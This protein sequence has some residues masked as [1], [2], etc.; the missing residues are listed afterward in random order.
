MQVARLNTLLR[1]Q[2]QV[3]RRHR[4]QLHGQRLARLLQDNPKEFFSRFRPKR[5]AAAAHLRA[6][7]WQQH[8][9]QLLG[10]APPNLPVP[11]Q[12]PVIPPGLQEIP[13]SQQAATLNVPFTTGDV[14]EAVRK[15]KSGRAVVGPLKP[16]VL[17]QVAP[18]LAPALASLLNACVRIGC[19]PPA[20][21]LSAITPTPKADSNTNVCNGY[22]GIAVGTLPAKLYAAILDRR[23]SNWAEGAGIRAAGQF[24]F[25][26]K[27][28]CA[29]AAFVLRTAIERQ[30]A[31]D[32]RL[33]ACF[34]DF[35]KAYDTVPRHLLWVKLQRAGLHGWFLQA[36]QALYAD[37]P[38]CVKTATG[39]T[40]PF[41]SLLGVKQGCPLSPNLFG[42]YVDDI[43]RTMLADAAAMDLPCM[44]DGRP[45]PPLLYADD[46]V[47]LATSAEGLQKQ[48]DALQAYSDSWGL[49][50]NA[51]KTKV[52]AFGRR[53]CAASLTDAGVGFTC[54]NAL[55]SI[56]DE[57]KYLGIQFHSSQAF[58]KAAAARAASGRRAV[59]ATRRRCTELGLL[60]PDLHMRMFNTMA[61]PVL[62]YGA[63]IWS[64]Q[65]VAAGQEC[66]NTRVQMSFLRQM[67]GVRQ[68]TPSLVVLAESGHRPLA[69][70]WTLQLARFWNNL[71][72]S[73]ED[74]LLQ[75]ALADSIDLAAN[76]AGPLAQQPWAAQFAAAMRC[77]NVA[78]DLQNPQQ[79]RVG[80]VREGCTDWLLRQFSDAQG[81][82]IRHY[83][84]VVR[85]GAADDAC[86][87]A[88][89]LA[90][91]PQRARRRALAQ[92][93]TGAHWLAEETGR[94]QRQER[95][96]RLCVHCSTLG[97]QHIETVPHFIFAC[98]RTAALRAQFPQ[99]FQEAN[100]S[101]AQFF[102]QD[103]VQL[104]S[105]A[106]A[107][108]S[109][110][111]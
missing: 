94:W 79:L 77:M 53:R 58:C 108:Y 89:Y 26:R 109:L 63:E 18:L 24:G 48:L 72:A 10:V 23:L 103:S 81:T 1:R 73:D 12:P 61:L 32:G 38:M 104:A 78:V 20:W 8:F 22:R 11:A 5:P 49:T 75:R 33:F 39:C 36:V 100:A 41:Q 92:L 6:D 96:E 66:D 28:S 84:D 88:S 71:L 105:F 60:S 51:G 102:A 30:R 47:L 97:H 98:P 35:Q 21:A 83:F 106:R 110:D 27:R 9:Q 44:H 16:L 56:V 4:R 14:L 107:C 45:V 37:V 40:A 43:E 90:V 85:G 15:T 93:R 2:A 87:P 29:R 52:V 3:E 50:V 99:L 62:S 86:H 74:S 67:L 25:R 82:K 7:Q 68:S 17:P 95:Q 46:L 31:N 76:A 19:L 55:L 80:E 42:M 13:T 34:V 70:H 64:P 69:V 101:L 54:G 111:H 59:H 91:L 65:L 57:F